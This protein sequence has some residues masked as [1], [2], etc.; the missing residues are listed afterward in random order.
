MAT[1]T[2]LYEKINRV[3]TQILASRDPDAKARMHAELLSLNGRLPKPRERTAE[4]DVSCDDTPSNRGR[5]FLEREAP[6]LLDNAAILGSL[7]TKQPVWSTRY[8]RKTRDESTP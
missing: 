7:L 6:H 2:D 3:T 5:A 1:E 8:W 4:F